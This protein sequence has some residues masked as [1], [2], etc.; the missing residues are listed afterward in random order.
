MT[1]TWTAVIG[2]FAVL[3]SGCA[4]PSIGTAPAP[5]QLA[6][7]EWSVERLGS[8][9]GPELRALT[10]AFSGASRVSG[11]DG[12][13]A[14]TG[15]VTISEAGIHV[16]ERLA[17]TM[18]A[19]PDSVEARARAYRAALMGATGYRVSDAKLTLTDAAGNSL[20][21]F[22]AAPVSLAGTRWEAISYNNGKHAVV[23]V[24]S[25]TMISATFGTD[26]RLT[27]NAGCNSYFAG[28]RLSGRSIAIEPPGATRR[29]CA[30]P[31]GVM[32]QEARYLQALA[33]ATQYRVS[34]DRLELRNDQGSLMA[35]F[36]RRGGR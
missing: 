6:D 35:I 15:G 36:A 5:Q 8:E 17:G 4:V 30:D 27:G 10:L 32:E 18:M 9:G 34:G 14:F 13:N 2:G 3:A 26:G 24:V 1:L 33:T 29:A 28:Y 23:S 16:D 19:C 21:V 20:V 12:C 31:A 25:G 7:T 22:A 11:N